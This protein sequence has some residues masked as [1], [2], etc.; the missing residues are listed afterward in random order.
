MATLATINET[1][2]DQTSSIEDGTRTTEGLR[3][4]FGQFIDR[5]VGSAGDNREQEIKERQK[6]SRKKVIAQRPQNFTQGLTQGLGFGGGMGFGALSQKILA[7]MGIAMGGI[8]LAAGKLLSF[9]PAIAVFSKFGEQA[10]SGLVDYVEDTYFD[11]MQLEKDTKKK[12]VDGVQTSIGARLLGV[13]SP[14]GLAIAGIVGAYGDT[15]ISAINEK[16]GH[17][18]GVY[19]IPGTELDIDTQSEAFISAL[20]VTMSLVAPAILRLAGKGL[21]KLLLKLGAGRAAFAMGAAVAGMLGLK[22]PF[23]ASGKPPPIDEM[24]D[25]NAKN[26]K[27]P[28]PV[29]T[30]KTPIPQV[31]AAAAA[32]ARMQKINSPPTTGRKVSSYGAPTVRRDAQGRFRSLNDPPG[33]GGKSK[34]IILAKKQADA[35]IKA[36]SIKNNAAL[37]KTAGV[38]LKVAGPLALA[39]EAHQGATNEDLNNMPTGAAVATQITTSYTLGLLDLLQNGYAT[40]DNMSRTAMNFGLNAIGVNEDYRFNMAPMSDL[41]GDTRRFLNK[42]YAPPSSKLTLPLLPDG[43]VPEHGLPFTGGGVVDKQLFDS[44]QQIRKQGIS[45]SGSMTFDQSINTRH[46]NNDL[47]VFSVTPQT[48]NF[49][50]LN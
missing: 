42:A 15:A 9:G 14:L 7:G 21:L 17:K 27:P 44:M 28:G 20:G 46:G 33:E 43:T 50:L 18:D 30:R 48:D 6:E 12:L 11:G 29:V 38:L 34:A 35:R 37:K 23:A 45:S 22:N 4:R 2:K 26:K 19:T 49:M 40:L 5:Q 25:A 3:D 1:L 10:I 8:G 41:A 36:E 13:K 47:T 16:F 31:N 32:A 39:Y 24:K